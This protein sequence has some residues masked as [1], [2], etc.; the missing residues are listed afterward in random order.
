MKYIVSL[1]FGGLLMTSSLIAQNSANNAY[2]MMNGSPATSTTEDMVTE[3]SSRELFVMENS[4]NDYYSATWTRDIYREVYDVEGN[5]S[6]FYPAVSTDKRANLFSLLVNLI[7]DNTITVYKFEDQPDFNDNS[8]LTAKEVMEQNRIGF[9]ENDNNTL[10][11]KREDLA[12]MNIIGYLVK[13]RWYYDIK[14]GK[15]DVRVQAICPVVCDRGRQ[16]PMFWAMFDDVSVYLARAISPVAVANITP[17]LSNASIYD[18][19]RNRYYRGC[20]YR[21]GMRD[22]GKYFTTPE[23]LAKERQRIETELDFVQSRFDAVATAHHEN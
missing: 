16:F 3:I 5:E 8:A 18:I 19:F 4:M 15:G 9:T 1:M 22:L 17:V 11:V 12:N 13:E 21:V 10:A 20:I 2:R 14:T 6:L 23:S 7:S